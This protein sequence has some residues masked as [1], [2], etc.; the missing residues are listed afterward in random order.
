MDKLKQWV[1]LTVVG[2]LA[3]L[4][5][6]WFLLVSPKRSEAA[7]VRTQAAS[8]VS[9]NRSLE[10]QLEV[11]KA[12]AAELP[13]EQAKLAAVAAKVPDNP[14]LPGLVRALIEASNSSGIELI[15][16]TPGEPV[17]VAPPA[18]AAPAAPAAGQQA[19]PAPGAP[20]APAAPGATPVGPAGQLAS[21][22]VSIEVHGDYFEAQQFVA[23]LEELSR[24]LRVTNLAVVPGTSPTQEGDVSTEDGRNLTTTVKGLVFMAANRP[25][26]TAATVPGAEGAPADAAA[27]DA[28][29]AETAP[30]AG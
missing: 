30:A 29:P 7:D 6:G 20:A 19:P 2:C 4:A 1:A 28:A 21:I 10:T 3:I 22:D 16:I 24:A 18:A 26:P 15:S 23:A 25:A 13:K 11:L 14:N 9:A 5:A 8:Q 27:A 12:Q 17:L